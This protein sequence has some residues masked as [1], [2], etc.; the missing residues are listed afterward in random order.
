ME[1]TTFYNQ[2]LGR[3]T[4]V[5]DKTDKLIVK[6]DVEEENKIF[7]NIIFKNSDAPHLINRK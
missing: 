5:H 3:K 6:P 1:M 7:Q 2:H 4:L